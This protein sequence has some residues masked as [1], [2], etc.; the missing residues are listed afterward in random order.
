VSLPTP[1]LPASAPKSLT[2]WSK[3]RLEPYLPLGL[4]AQKRPFQPPNV[5]PPSPFDW[6][7]VGSAPPFN[8]RDC[9]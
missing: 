6:T 5:V 1:P 4:R 3:T 8:R 7:G 2:P 9:D